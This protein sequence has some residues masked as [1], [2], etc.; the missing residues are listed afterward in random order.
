MKNN[1]LLLLCMVLVS[2]SFGQTSS[3]PCGAG[4]LV[5]NCAPNTI[6]LTNTDF[7][8][9]ITD[10]ITDGFTCT[11]T[12]ASSIVD[13][14]IWFTT[15]VDASGQVDVYANALTDDPV[16]GIYSGTCTSLTL[17]ACDDDGGTGLDALASAT[18]LAPGS[19]VWIRVWEYTGLSGASATY[20][21][22]S[23]GG[24]PPVNDDCASPTNLTLN[25]A[26]I[27]G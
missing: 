17:E 9:G 16:V 14:D 23:S 22:A 11:Y 25:A 4:P 8:S 10:P 13:V 20:E 26:P 19:T 27:N 6:L 3:N 12:A 5:N 21:I 7:N 18:G 15:T 2:T 1:L 24:V